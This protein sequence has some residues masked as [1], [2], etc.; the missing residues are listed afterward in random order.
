MN[1]KLIIGIASAITL[2]AIALIWFLMSIHYVNK[3]IDLRA[4]VVA[5]Q[6]KC[7]GHFDTMWKILSEKAGVTE[8]YKDAFKDIYPDLIAGR[9][10]GNQDG[11]L[12]KWVKESNPNFDTSLYKDLMAS[13]ESERTG[14]LNEQDRLID[15][16]KEH[17]TFIVKRPAKWFLD[18]DLKEV[19]IKT[20]SSTRTNNAFETGKEDDYDLFKKN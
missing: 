15:L 17:K 11:S 10:S 13:I 5:Q 20:I 12:M 9:Y 18:S 7:E 16:Q 3:E 4:Q 2:G 1:K 6:K 14:Y 8:Q 19:A